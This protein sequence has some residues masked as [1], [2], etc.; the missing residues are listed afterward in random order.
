MAKAYRPIAI[1]AGVELKAQPGQAIVKG[2][3]GTLNVALFTGVSVKVESGRFTVE[4]GAEVDR[5]HVGTARAHIVNAFTGVTQ[6]FVKVL[7]VRGMGYRV[8]KT[9][10]GVQILCGFSHPLD[11]VAPAGVTF[12]VN[13]APDPEDQK[14]QMS[15]ITIKGSNRQAVGEIAAEIRAWKPPDNYLGKGIRYR[16]ERVVKKQGKRA[17]GTQA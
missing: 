7:E 13:Q 12:D 9:K 17:A 2:K 14:I 5:A 1:P 11:I 3:L 16:G 8:Q 6:G 10:D 4:A 15:E